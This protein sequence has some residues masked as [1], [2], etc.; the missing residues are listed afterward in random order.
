M[1]K[2]PQPMR[3]PLGCSHS[4]P[5]DSAVEEVNWLAK[6]ARPR[7]VDKPRRAHAVDDIDLAIE[8]LGEAR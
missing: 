1:D 5:G 8:G 3:G 6:G 2:S 4:S 7:R